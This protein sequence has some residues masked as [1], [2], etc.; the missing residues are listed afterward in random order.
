MKTEQFAEW[1]RR[2]GHRIVSSESC[3]WFDPGPRIFEALPYHAV[4]DPAPEEIRRMLV[5][6]KGVAARYFTPW[7][8]DSGL[9]SYHVVRDAAPYDLSCLNPKSRNKVRRGLRSCTVQ[10]IPL[11][12]MMRAG[13]PLQLDTLQRHNRVDSLSKEAWQR[14]FTN[15]RDLPDFTAWG[16]FVGEELASIVLIACVEGVAYLLYQ[17]S[18]QRFFKKA[19]N[20][21]LIFAVTR[22]MLARPDVRMIFYS[23]H[24]LD[25]PV[26]VDDFKFGMD[27]WARPYRQQ[28]QFHPLLSPF[29]N[30][31]SHR[32]LRW[33]SG[34]ITNNALSKGEG[35]LRFYLAGRLLP[36]QQPWPPCL[37]EQRQ[38]LLQQLADLVPRENESVPRLATT[39][40]GGG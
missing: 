8:S 20:N 12:L 36:E 19:V 31:T 39:A 3:L 25:A 24:S 5:R 9:V 17:C 10:R 27:Y 35:M 28:I 23:T 2:Q 29:F 15:V 13:W 18:H 37:Q 14:V 40:K 22:E 1:L 38:E 21:A 26:S 11:A 33:L 16:A 32:L 4:I 6:E 30:A 34:R 7:Q